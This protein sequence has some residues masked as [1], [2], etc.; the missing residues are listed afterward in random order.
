[1][2]TIKLFAPDF[3]FGK[4]LVIAK[5]LYD[6]LC[7]I[8]MNPSTYYLKLARLI[9]KVKP[10]FTMVKSRNLVNLYSL[11]ERVNA[12]NL[13]GDIVECGVWN[14]GSAA[15]M[16][17]ADRYG[18]NGRNRAIWLFDS[19]AGLPRPGPN[20]GAAENQHYFEGF[21][22]G[23]TQQVERVFGNL[24]VPINH[25]RIQPGWFNSTLKRA[26]LE[27]IV[28]LHI[29]ADWYD[30]VMSVLDAFYEKVVPG[31]FVVLDDY[32]YWEGCTRALNDFIAQNNLER[33]ELKQADSTGVYFQK[34]TATGRQNYISKLTT[35]GQSSF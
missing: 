32:G 2:N 5:T 26:D 11:I 33:V 28:V 23:S 35:F 16:G 17:F 20:D 14:G 31:G 15:L 4:S 18:K 1:M 19:F 21:N 34:P 13:D 6:L 24:G 3:L 30:S 8:L 27:Q 12:M 10:T 29:D 22:K 9:L 25:V 7:I